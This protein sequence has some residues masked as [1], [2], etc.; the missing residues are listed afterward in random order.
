[1]V[2]LFFIFPKAMPGSRRT[3]H[4]GGKHRPWVQYAAYQQKKDSPRRRALR[5]Q[6]IRAD[7]AETSL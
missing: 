2:P 1:M 7:R 5:G 3:G 6:I 4:S